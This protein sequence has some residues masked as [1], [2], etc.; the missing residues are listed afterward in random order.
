MHRP[1]LHSSYLEIPL[2]AIFKYFVSQTRMMP[3]TYVVSLL[4]LIVATTAAAAEPPERNLPA[5]ESLFGQPVDKAPDFLFGRPSV[6]L[7]IRGLWVNTRGDS[8]V[9]SFL[10]EKLTLEKTAFR[11]KGV[12]FD[13]GLPVRPRI[14]ALVGLEY[15]STNT[16]SEDREFIE[17]DGNP[18][19][20]RTSLTQFNLTGSFELA[21]LPRGRSVGQFVW[22]SA[23]VTPYV[24]GGAGLLWYRLEQTGDFVDALDPGLTIFTAQL[25]S[26]G[27][28]LN[29]HVFMGA[30]I[31]VSQHIFLTGEARY[32]WASAPMNLDYTGF[33]PIDLSGLRVSGGI[34]VVF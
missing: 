26:E 4:V 11:Q 10:T 18:I 34:Q 6:T 33:E 5:K 17:D 28:A 16:S 3:R 9:F 30:D 23:P 1:Q 2:D 32:M 7:G 22:I 24:G 27:W 14:D 31:K 13:I 20:Q 21:L 29:S 8:D 19:E 25:F 15:A 12:A